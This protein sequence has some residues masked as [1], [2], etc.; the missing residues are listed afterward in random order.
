[1]NIDF[2]FYISLILRRTPVMAIFVLVCAGL[3]V[4]TALKLPETYSTAARLLVEAPQISDDLVA[5]T[6]QTNANEQLDIIEQRLLTRANLIDIANRV[7]VFADIRSMDPDTVVS[8]MSAQTRIRRTTGREQATLMTVS[9]EGRSGRVAQ[10]VVNE[11]VTLILE[12]NVEFRLSRAESTLDFFEEEVRRIGQELDQQSGEIVTFKTANAAALP[13]DQSYRLN[14]QTLL[15]ERLSR[16]E[17]DRASGQAQRMDIVRIFENTGSVRNQNGRAPARSVEEQ[18]LIAARVD[19]ETLKA[20]YSDTNPRVVRAQNRVDRL[21]AIVAAQTVTEDP[22]DEEAT[23]PE[24]AILAATLSEI[25]NRLSDVDREIET[26]TAEL[27]DLASSITSSSSNGIV[28]AALERTFEATQ[29]RYNNAV[30]NLNRAKLGERIETTAQGQRITIIE[31]ANVPN[32]P[33]GP[34][35]PKIAAAGVA[36]GLGLA[37]AYFLLLE[38][39]NRTIRR[40]VEIQN[41][42]G[43]TPIAAIPYMEGRRQKMMRRIGLVSAT[44]VVMIAVPLAL[45]Y[46]DQTYLPLEIVV[47]KGLTRL[48]L[49]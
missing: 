47:Q 35:R 42:F 20:D 23:S 1:M 31:N 9:F 12:A 2:R 39:L 21:E 41:R 27:E 16:L 29:T 3:G 11:Y 8:R 22:G 6:V 33:T 34:N 24:E 17:R 25:D 45:W 19:L 14:R 48:G 38:V 36:A 13:E 18:Q 7:G 49:G 43:I 26:T 30:T 32:A 44:V 40:P 46:I 5:S 10:A 15:Q 28:L 37:A 4:I